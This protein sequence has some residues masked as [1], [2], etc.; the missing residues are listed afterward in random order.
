M[1]DLL[2]LVTAGSVDG[3]KSTMIGR[4]LFDS[5]HI[6]DDQLAAI[7]AAS[8][9]RSRGHL[10]LSLLT[11]GLRAEREQGITI[12]VAYRYF[13]T[14]N[15]KFVIADTPGHVQYTR[16]MVT[17]ASTAAL[18]V[19]VVDIVK[20]LVE[21]TRRHA[22]LA[23]LLGVRTLVVAVNK[24]D[25]VDFGEEAFA[26]LRAE[27]ERF[28][29]PLDFRE[30]AFIPMSALRGDNVVHASDAM[31]WYDG[32]PLLAHLETVDVAAVDS[33]PHLRLPV[34]LVLRDGQRHPARVYA[35]R[36]LAGTVGVGDEVLVLPAQVRTRI[37]SVTSSGAPVD[38][39]GA[40]A[41]VAVAIADDIDV[42]RGFMLVD[43]DHPP[44]IV[45]EFSAIVCWMSD[46]PMQP[47]TTYAIKHTTSWGKAIVRSIDFRYDV[48]DLGHPEQADMLVSNDIGRI[49]LVS[50]TPLFA[51]PY[52]ANRSTGS[53]I[54]VDELTMNTVAAG[55]IVD[56]N[57]ADRRP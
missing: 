19:L 22:T 57:D 35:G 5:K 4:L 36:L 37:E 1:A 39:A 14:P 41:S 43:A 51:D 20:G 28:C 12:D 54:L 55:M 26:K 6:F 33:L 32:L 40:P 38:R 10:D 52:A 50:T 16:N 45:R 29:A 34:Q 21:Q 2:R 9:R 23:S 15:R 27:F 8:I 44:A 48:K 56:D 17:G 11:D 24:M 46:R 53:F 3:G 47:D 25:V 42:S 7:E 13:S 49:R 31:P 18:C 30:I